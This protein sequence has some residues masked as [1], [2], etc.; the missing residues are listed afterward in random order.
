MLFKNHFYLFGTSKHCEFGL[1]FSKVWPFSA[2]SNRKRS[3]SKRPI[4]KSV[5]QKDRQ[6]T[7][8]YFLC[9]LKVW[10]V[11]VKNMNVTKQRRCQ[12]VFSEEEMAAVSDC[13]TIGCVVWCRTCYNTEFEGE[14]I[15]FDTNSKILILSI[16]FIQDHRK[17]WSVKIVLYSLYIGFIFSF[18]KNWKLKAFF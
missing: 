11:G 13:F 3:C 5:Y 9:V 2:F 15:S 8:N 6:S 17:P 14:V 12:C 18:I 10:Q 1:T 7:K 4:I 16:L